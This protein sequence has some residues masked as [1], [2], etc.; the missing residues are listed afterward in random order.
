[1]YGMVDDIWERF[2]EELLGVAT[3]LGIVAEYP[4]DK[5]LVMFVA[6]KCGVVP[7]TA[8]ESKYVDDMMGK[9]VL[10]GRIEGNVQSALND[11]E[12]YKAMF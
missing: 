2:T 9:V 4:N 11:P 8:E 12:F 3:N 1:M 5:L 7:L 10:T 6:Y